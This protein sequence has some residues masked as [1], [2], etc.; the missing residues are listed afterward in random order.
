MDQKVWNWESLDEKL[1]FLFLSSF[2]FSF[3]S[4]VSSS[5]R[6]TSSFG[7]CFLAFAALAPNLIKLEIFEMVSDGNDTNK[8][9]TETIRS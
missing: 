4:D 9:N 8:K 6:T 2:F 7:R 3:S 1:F 5:A